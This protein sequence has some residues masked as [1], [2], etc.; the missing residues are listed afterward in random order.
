MG[1]AESE[2]GENLLPFEL[3]N[4]SYDRFVEPYAVVSEERKAQDS[5]YDEDTCKS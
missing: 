1:V 3:C 5:P 2:G 4:Q